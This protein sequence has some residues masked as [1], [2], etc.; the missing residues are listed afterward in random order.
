MLITGG[1]G[2]EIGWQHTQS[3]SENLDWDFA[4][5]SL[6]GANKVLLSYHSVNSK[7]VFTTLIY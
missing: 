7:H 4:L 6:E 2:L 5:L 3:F 1:E